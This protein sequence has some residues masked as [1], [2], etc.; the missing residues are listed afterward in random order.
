MAETLARL[1]GILVILS[2]VLPVHNYT[3]EAEPRLVGRPPEKISELNRRIKRYC[4][5]NGCLYLDYFAAVADDN[6]L[7]KRELAADGLHPGPAGYEI[8]APLAESAIVQLCADKK[9]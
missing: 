4:A 8:M 2:S 6:G 7:L 3:V 9:I 5:Q 1:H